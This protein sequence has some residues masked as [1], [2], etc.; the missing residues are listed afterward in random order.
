MN[1]TSNTTVTTEELNAFVAAVCARHESGL[2]A[3]YPTC[4]LNWER[5]E[6]TVGKRYAKLFTLRPEVNADYEITGYRPSSAFAFIDLTTGNILKPA[7][8]NTPAKHARGN[9][10][11]G[12]PS[13]LWCGAFTNLG[14]GLH[15]AYLR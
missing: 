2:K 14:G 10:R 3:E 11:R 4:N 1:E 7:G 13:D 12:G 8:C 6:H 9:I 5:I 15:V